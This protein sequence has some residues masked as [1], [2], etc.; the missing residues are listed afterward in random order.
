M[1]SD[2][3]AQSFGQ[4]DLL[5]LGLICLLANLAHKLTT[6]QADQRWVLC[7]ELNTSWHLRA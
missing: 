7:R 3:R 5:D 2:A 1:K 4:L 6:V